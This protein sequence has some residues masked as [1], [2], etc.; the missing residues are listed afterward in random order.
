MKG[1]SSFI[2]ACTLCMGQSLFAQEPIYKWGEPSTN[3]FL[4]RHIDQLLDLDGNGF[5]LLR[6]KTAST[7]VS[8]Y[9]LEYYNTELKIE[10]IREVVFNGGVMGNSFDIE[11]ITVQNG[12]IYA[13]VSHWD[14]TAGEHSLSVKE[15]TLTGELV[16]IAE[17]DAIAAQKMGNRGV[18]RTTFSDD[19]SKLLVLSELPFVKKTKEKIR[20][21]CY[22]VP[23][24]KQLWKQDQELSWDSKRGANNHIAVN[25]AGQAFLFKKIWEKPDW[26]Y[27]LYSFDSK[28][29]WQ[30]YALGIEGK[31]IVDHRLE[32]NNDNEFILFA[33]YSTDPSNFDKKLHGTLF[34]HLDASMK[35]DANQ[36]E[37][38]K[39]ETVTFLAG[40]K[41]AGS[42]A[43][44][45][46][47]YDIKEI[48]FRNDGNMLVLMDQVKSERNGV[49]GTSPVQYVYE[50][51]YGNFLALCVQ[52]ASGE[53]VWW[54]A[55]N[56][57]Q[58]TRLNRDVDQYGSY[59]YHLK[60]DR[61]Y[62]LWNNTELS[63]PSIPPANWTEP[64]GTKYVKHKAFDE[65]TMH[66]TFMHV[67]EPNGVLAY[68]NRVFGLPLFQLHQGAVFEMSLTTPF[69]FTLNG[70]LVVMAE[71]HNGG[72]RY[73]FGIIDL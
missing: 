43:P 32:F 13:F 70:D 64:D 73:R 30:D 9:W 4:D 59:I 65:K 47:N 46:M 33:T 49:P 12:R 58:N 15:L 14:K 16:D 48:L 67:I 71:M 40:E 18:F 37:G 53:L 1:L 11:E 2:L 38:W 6:R 25:N 5:V 50:W 8:T 42:D 31:Q 27:A 29:N 24:M 22:D 66:A 26:K 41:M 10:G 56:K 28:G 17:L 35:M 72:K 7:S 23:T 68:E 62:I 52:P 36:A 34:V 44:M 54:Q 21:S 51:Q 3:D 20:L 61:L 45:L 55:F 39:Q 19:G 63:V 60:E 69:F 57:R